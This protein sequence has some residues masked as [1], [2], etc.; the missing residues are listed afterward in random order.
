MEEG[1]LG[2]GFWE[3]GRRGQARFWPWLLREKGDE[4]G[5]GCRRERERRVRSGDLSEQ[6]RCVWRAGLRPRRLGLLA[7]RLAR[8]FFSFFVELPQGEKT[9]YR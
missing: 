4:V 2:L 7:W 5:S 8:G 1:R 6:G 3:R 9:N